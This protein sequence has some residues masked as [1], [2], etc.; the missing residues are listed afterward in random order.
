MK[1]PRKL[2]LSF[3]AAALLAGVLP[4]PS[5]AD[6]TGKEE[7]DDVSV[8]LDLALLRPVGFVATILG[9]AAFVVSLPIS[10]PTGSAGKTFN[11]LVKEPAKY[12]FVRQLG[13]EQAE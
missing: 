6:T 10:L 9:T 11:A 7:G 3:T 4:A 12:T 8:A 13:E 5:L 1:S 2:I